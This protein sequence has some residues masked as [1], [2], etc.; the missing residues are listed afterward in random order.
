M[1]FAYQGFSMAIVHSIDKKNKKVIEMNA[2][3]F[4]KVHYRSKASHTLQVAISYPSIHSRVSQQSMYVF[5]MGG[6]KPLPDTAGGRLSPWEQQDRECCN[7][8]A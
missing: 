2:V 6:G 5:R 7:P 1:A 3:S 8:I 4:G